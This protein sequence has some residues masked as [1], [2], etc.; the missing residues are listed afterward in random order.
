MNKKISAAVAAILAAALFSSCGSGGDVPANSTDTAADI[1][2][3]SDIAS[4]GSQQTSSADTAV[5][6]VT[7][8]TAGEQPAA[9]ESDYLGSIMFVGDDMC[10]GFA[11]Q[12]GV[13]ADMVFASEGIDSE[14]IL[15]HSFVLSNGSYTADEWAGE[16]QPKYIYIWLGV[17]DLS[18]CNDYT[19]YMNMQ[20]VI[21][22]LHEAS[23]DSI[24]AV[25]DLSP[26]ARSS[27]WDAEVC[28]GDAKYDI[29]IYSSTISQLISDL[30]YDNLKYI[31]TSSVLAADGWLDE[32]YDSGDGMHLN[33]TA[34]DRLAGYI[35]ENRYYNEAMGDSESSISE[36]VPAETEI[37]EAETEAEVTEETAETEAAVTESSADN[38]N[39]NSDDPD[40]T[41]RY[42][43]LYS[44]RAPYTVSDGKVC[45]LTFDDGPSSNT[46]EILD[47]L[48][49]NNIKATFFI[50]GW[51]IDGRE[52]ILQ[53]I[54]D[55]GH[56]IGIHS[57]SHEYEEIYASTEAYLSDFNETYKK[58]Y[59]VTGVKP[60]AFRFP[61]GSRNSFNSETADDIIA[62]MSRRGF[63]FFDWS[64]A[65]S[66]ATVGATYDSCVENFRDTLGSDH[67]TVLMHDSKELTKEYLQDVIDYAKSEGYS[68]ETV[69]TADAVHF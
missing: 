44:T 9:V 55:E 33:K 18:Y 24:I 35:R 63:E 10:A 26:V 68:F 2:N 54:A 66:D 14:D 52:D 16:N 65:T 23:P 45:Y 15:G 30:G 34:Y 64:C 5:P 37:T 51:C 4:D 3:T 48:K 1:Q 59:E 61:G 69:D 42:P 56:T 12:D 43:D 8:P 60:W 62:E 27:S 13:N 17:N 39:E 40:Y 19:Y 28:G 53:R 57:Y 31:D 22:S 38:A 25:M 47:I 21:K 49:N 11:E 36:T 46:E 7:L 41:K 6:T 20:S 50:V 67:E 58:I 32:S 29:S